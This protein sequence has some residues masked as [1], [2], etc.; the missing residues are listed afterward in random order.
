VDCRVI[1][2]GTGISVPD[3][4]NCS[5]NL[6]QEERKRLISFRLNSSLGERERERERESHCVIP[7]IEQTCSQLLVNVNVTNPISKRLAKVV[8]MEKRGDT[9]SSASFLDSRIG[10]FLKCPAQ[11][12]LTFTQM[13][14]TNPE[15]RARLNKF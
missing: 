14:M 3:F 15:K 9:D 11:Q 5:S 12:L 4:N 6:S 7:V 2:I 13:Q 8:Q 1:G 10:I